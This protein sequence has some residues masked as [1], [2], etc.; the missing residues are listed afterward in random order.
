ML[1]FAFQILTVGADPILNR[2][3]M[4]G[5]IL[6]QIPCAS[7]SAF[8]ISLH[9]AGVCFV[10]TLFPIK[11]GLEHLFRLLTIQLKLFTWLLLSTVC[12]LLFIWSIPVYFRLLR[13]EVTDVLWMLSRNLAATCAHFVAN[14]FRKGCKAQYSLN[15]EAW[16]PE[17]KQQNGFQLNE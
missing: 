16:S 6:S 14:V 7:P 9:P 10:S 2:F 5:E 12:F 4:N 17:P 13:L 3:D 15:F 8:S 11:M 1:I